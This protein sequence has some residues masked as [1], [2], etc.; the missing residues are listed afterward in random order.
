[1]FGKGNKLYSMLRWKCAKCH[2]GDLFIRSNA[3]SFSNMDKMHEC[4]PNCKQTY[5][6]EPGFY[7]GTMYVSYAVSIALSVAVF[8]AMN[9]L[10]EFEVVRYLVINTVVLALAFPWMF[11]TS[12]AVWLNFFVHYEEDA[13][14]ADSVLD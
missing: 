13:E 3:Y 7:Y 12:R 5:W 14:K 9:V 1:M 4:C 10:W 8:V 6:P 11:R 2:E